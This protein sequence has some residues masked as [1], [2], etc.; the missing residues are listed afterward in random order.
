MRRFSPALVVS[1]VALAV[2]S[3][4]TGYAARGLIGSA[5]IKDHS[6]RLVDL[7]PATIA[8]LHG[9]AGAPGG[10]DASK[11]TINMGPIPHVTVQPGTV[12]TAEADCPAGAVAIS[13]GGYGSIAGLSSTGPTTQAGVG[14]PVGWHVLVANQ[15]PIPVDVFAYAVCVAAY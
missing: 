10:I 12:G 7:S 6:I 15:S 11:I 13:G 5:D 14:Y 3:T 1:M 9:A 8:A 4:G 2:A